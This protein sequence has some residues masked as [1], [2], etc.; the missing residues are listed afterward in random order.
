M[1]RKEKLTSVAL[2]M[3]QCDRFHVV[4]VCIKRPGWFSRGYQ[5]TE[6]LGVRLTGGN[7]A[8]DSLPGGEVTITGN[9]FPV[10]VTEIH[11]CTPS[12]TAILK[13]YG[14][15]DQH[16]RM[17]KAGIVLPGQDDGRGDG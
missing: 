2:T 10:M 7:F 17:K 11:P 8:L 1:G 4:G 13:A 16:E 5:I 12:H 15:L 9:D 6:A 3:V 14:E